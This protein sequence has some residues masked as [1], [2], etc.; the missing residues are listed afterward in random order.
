MK[1]ATM[2][3]MPQQLKDAFLKV[4]PDTGRLRIM[5]NRDC[6]RMLDFE[7]WTDAQIRSI[8][9]PTFVIDG[10]KD[11]M[12]PENAV[13]MYRLIPDCQLAIVPGGHG[14]YMGEITTL[15]GNNK[16]SLLIVPLIVEFLNKPG[17]K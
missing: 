12:T 7:G 9:A 16:D 6:G 5:F 3:N 14:E 1:H 8:S 15:S 11:V 4:N 13:E 2:A 17:R 10:D